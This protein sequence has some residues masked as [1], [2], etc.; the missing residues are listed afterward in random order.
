MTNENAIHNTVGGPSKLRWGISYLICVVIMAILA[1]TVSAVFDALNFPVKMGFGPFLDKLVSD[2]KGLGPLLGGVIAL[3]ALIAFL[4]AE[5]TARKTGWARGFV[6]TVAGL[7]LFIVMFKLL[8]IR[9]FGTQPIGGARFLPGYL[10]E[11]LVGVFGG[12]LFARL[13]RTKS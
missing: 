5:L 6:F 11:L 7:V 2:V 9:G 10:T 13:T 3:G 1:V 4:A 8:E 12:W